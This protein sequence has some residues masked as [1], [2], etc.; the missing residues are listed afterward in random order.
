MRQSQL[1]YKTLKEAP[2]EAETISHQLLLRGGFIFQLA[3][4][5]Y[6]FLPLG[7]KVHKKIENIIREEMKKIGAQE[8][9]LAALQPKEIWEKT[10]RWEKMTPPLFKLK[11]RHRK[12]FALGPTHEEAITQLAKF[13]IQSYEDLPFYLFQIQSKF[14][15]EMRSTGGLLRVREFLMKDL[16]SFH[17]SEEDFENYFEK[18]ANSYEK[19]FQKFNLEVIKSEASGGPFTEAGAKTYEFQV[20][21]E[22]GEDRILFCQKCKF[23]VNLEKAKTRDIC[24]KCKEKLQKVNTIEVGHI[25][26]LGNKYSEAFQLYFVDKDG[27]KKPVIMGCY[28]IGIGR[29]MATIVEIH[30]DEKGIIW[31]PS[32]APFDIHLLGLGS[33]KEKIREKIKKVSEKIYQDL[34]KRGI[35]ILYDD[36][37]DKTAGE[38]FAEADLIGIPYRMVISKK[39]LAKNSVELKKRGDKKLKLVKIKNLSKFLKNLC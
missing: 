13:K 36:R 4:G 17:S 39:T 31:P 33:G 16:Y 32:V 12:D 2:K 37:P 5:I 35:E 19:I 22:S 18:V 3:A 25:F 20:P 10:D 21:A 1:F 7:W 14:R 30:H 26:S 15:N 24:P 34:E 23:A 27:V 6:N 8:I 28:G 11:D 38:K 9:F 29:L